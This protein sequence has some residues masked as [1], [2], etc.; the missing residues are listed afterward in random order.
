MK[1]IAMRPQDEAD[2]QERFAAYGIGL[3]LDFIRAEL[4]TFSEPDDPRRAK[5]ETW[6]REAKS[7][8]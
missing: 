5:F 3:D 8:R 1:L 6:V 2:I 7:G 4:E